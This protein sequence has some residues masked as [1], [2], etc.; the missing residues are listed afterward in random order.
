[1]FYIK[2]NTEN[3]KIQYKMQTYVWKI[4]PVIMTAVD[5]NRIFLNICLDFPK[6]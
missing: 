1:M 4:I 3:E 6:I 2:N 5:C